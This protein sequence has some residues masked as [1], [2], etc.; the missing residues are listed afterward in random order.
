M[1]PT[2]KEDH[3]TSTKKDWREVTILEGDEMVLLNMSKKL[4][5]K[6]D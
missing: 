6:A 2:V 4:Y 1:L 5:L 3:N